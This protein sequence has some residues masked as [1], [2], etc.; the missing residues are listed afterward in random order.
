M[1]FTYHL[2]APCCLQA[3]R[4]AMPFLETLTLVAKL[5][6]TVLSLLTSIAAIFDKVCAFLGKMC[7]T[8]Q[9]RLGGEG[10]LPVVQNGLSSFWIRLIGSKTC[11]CDC[12]E[13]HSVVSSCE[14]EWILMHTLRTRQVWRRL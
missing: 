1:V 11:K 6:T 7:E 5:F 4:A 13:E 14:C 2:L 9:F 10:I 8:S 3:S 12:F